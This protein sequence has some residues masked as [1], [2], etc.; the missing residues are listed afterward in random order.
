MVEI[1]VLTA[2]RTG[3]DFFFGKSS[4]DFFKLLAG[5]EHHS[6]IAF[7][8]FV[9]ALLRLIALLG[10]VL[11]LICQFQCFLLVLADSLLMM[12]DRRK[13]F[14]MLGFDTDEFLQFTFAFICLLESTVGLI[15]AKLLA[16]LG[17]CVDFS[18]SLFDIVMRFLH[19]LLRIYPTLFQCLRRIDRLLLLLGFECDILQTSGILP[20]LHTKHIGTFMD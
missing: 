15:R 6:V 12:L 4:T 2:E 16:L 18:L 3:I 9:V 7:L 19:C 5:T 20:D 8:S 1:D 14:L 10:Q 17:K 11:D 13:G